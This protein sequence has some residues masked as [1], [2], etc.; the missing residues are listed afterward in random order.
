MDKIIAFLAS[1][2]RPIRILVFGGILLAW[3]IMKLL[4]TLL[5]IEADIDRGFDFAAAL[6]IICSILGGFGISITVFSYLV[7]TRKDGEDNS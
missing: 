4:E 3:L 1:G 7:S 2:N 5:G 6:L